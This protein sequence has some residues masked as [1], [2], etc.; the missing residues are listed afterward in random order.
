MDFTL[1]INFMTE[2]PATEQ[3]MLAPHRVKP[4]QF[5]GINDEQQAAILHERDQ[6][7]DEHALFKRQREEEDRLWAL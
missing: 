6:Q 7:L 2:N 3:P 1:K 5:K 4:Y